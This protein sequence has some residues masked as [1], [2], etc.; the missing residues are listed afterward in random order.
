MTY[1]IRPIHDGDLSFLWD[2]LYESLYVS[3]GDTPFPRDIVQDPHLAKYVMD[4][5]RKGD[6]GFI[7]MNA[8]EKPIGSITARF[9]PE[10]N[11]GFGYV[12]ED[13]PE[14]GMAILEPYRGAG[15]G[16]ALLKEL[17]IQ[18]QRQQ[19]KRVSLSVDPGNLAAMSLYQ[20]FGFVEV[21]QVGTS[22]TMVA[23]IYPVSRS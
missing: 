17:F 8:E 11:K 10:D 18:L 20:R 14:L 15:V 21:D 19:V 1:R 6:V 2:T 4:W 22:I 9:Y 16:T 5:G 7:A 3:E 23:D 12:A 13:V